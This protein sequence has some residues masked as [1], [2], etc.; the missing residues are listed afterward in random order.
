MKRQSALPWDK[1]QTFIDWASEPTL[2]GENR[3]AVLK[4]GT[5]EMKMAMLRDQL[6]VEFEDLE[7]MHAGLEQIIHKGSIPWWWW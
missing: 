2:D 5:P 7:A 4:H 3:R 1:I 6:G